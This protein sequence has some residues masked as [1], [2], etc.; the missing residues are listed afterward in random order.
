[1]VAEPDRVEVTGVADDGSS[2]VINAPT[3]L[4]GDLAAV[5][6]PR[7]LER[8]AAP[9]DGP[10]SHAELQV[11]DGVVQMT[12]DEVP[13]GSRWERVESE[14][15]LFAAE[16]LADLVAVHSAVLVAGGRALLVPGP[17][18]AGKSSLCLAAAEAG[19][20][21]LSDEYALVDP[22]TGLV[23]GWPRQVR[24]RLADGTT[25]LHDLV[26]ASEP[27]LVGLVAV[28]HH[29]A[30]AE[31]HLEEIRSAD[32]VLELLA[33]TVCASSRPHLALDAA[34]AVA[35]AASAVKGTRQ[36]AL[37][38][39]RELLDRMASTAPR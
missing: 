8:A 34:L 12:I 15:A 5:W 29:D 21:V 11:V 39:L 22:A 33:N 32:T 1:M 6:P 23:T 35:R 20:S 28:V 16:R 7:G 30:V 2:I 9:G 26:V 31:P 38:A 10:V 18:R 3:T 37:P 17:S 27:V 14:L 36:E 25:A 24:Q 13:V 19:A 4:Q